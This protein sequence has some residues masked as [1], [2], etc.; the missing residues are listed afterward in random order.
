MLESSWGT[1]SG[2]GEEWG[3]SALLSAHSDPGTIL[4]SSSE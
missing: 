4:W 1:S 3:V 2:A